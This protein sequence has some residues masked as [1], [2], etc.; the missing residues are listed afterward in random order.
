MSGS[1]E[2]LRMNIALKQP[3]KNADPS[4][5]LTLL[6]YSQNNMSAS[7]SGYASG[8]L[9]FT[10]EMFDYSML[11]TDFDEVSTDDKVRIRSLIEPDSFTLAE[12]P[13]AVNGPSYF[14][15]HE[16]KTQSPL[17]DARLSI[18]I[19]LVDSLSSDISMIFSSYDAL[20]NAIGDPSLD[21]SPDYP[22]LAVLRDVYFNRISEK[23]NFRKFFDFYKWFDMSVSTFIEQLVPAKTKY[24]GTNF[25]VESHLLERHKNMYFHNEMYMGDLKIVDNQRLLLQQIETSVK[26][27]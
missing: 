8:T 26:K 4:G 6:D 14:H 5:K 15:E 11:S 1:F 23:L 24:K 20:S 13:W 2:K 25:V 7:V 10:G 22:S 9:A 16:I 19:S 12:N 21:F 3:V 17:D 27:Y 18:E